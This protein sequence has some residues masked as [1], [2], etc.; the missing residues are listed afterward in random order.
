MSRAGAGSFFLGAN[1]TTRPMRTA[2]WSKGL[3]ASGETSKDH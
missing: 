2:H 1:E 3:K